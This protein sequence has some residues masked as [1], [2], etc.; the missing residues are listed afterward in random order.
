VFTE[1]MFRVNGPNTWR[2]WVPS[3]RTCYRKW[4]AHNITLCRKKTRYDHSV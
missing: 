1:T 4:P 2:E 3:W